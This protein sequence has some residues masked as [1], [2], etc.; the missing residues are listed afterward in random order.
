MT[1]ATLIEGKHLLE[2]PYNFIDV[3]WDDRVRKHGRTQTDALLEKK[4][5]GLHLDP[6]GA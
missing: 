4:Q 2:L 3:A 1:M 6:Q 5:R